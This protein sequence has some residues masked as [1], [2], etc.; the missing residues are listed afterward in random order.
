MERSEHQFMPVSNELLVDFTPGVYLHYKNN[1]YLA[2]EVGSD[3]NFSDRSVVHYQPLDRNGEVYGDKWVRT[4]IHVDQESWRDFVHRDGS[5]CFRTIVCHESGVDSI[6]RFRYL[7]PVY[8]SWMQ[9]L[10]PWK[11]DTD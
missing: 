6:P 4:L 1:L 8:E 9:N 3:A 11:T 10:D 5:K 2:Y 7:G